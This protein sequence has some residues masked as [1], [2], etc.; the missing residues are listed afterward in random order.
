MP[1][2]SP[3]K[4]LWQKIKSLF[5]KEKEPAPLQ[6]NE[7][8][9]TKT[10]NKKTAKKEQLNQL[11]E[12]LISRQDLITAGK[13]HFLGLDQ[14]KEK[15]GDSW[16]EMEK[17]VYRIVEETIDKHKSA[18]DLF[19]RYK[20]DKYLIIFAHNDVE[21]SKQTIQTIAKEVRD[22]L[23][24][25]EEQGY[26]TGIQVAVTQ[27]E[28]SKL[29]QSPD[30]DDKLEIMFRPEE[31]SPSTIK[32]QEIKAAPAK[33][34]LKTSAPPKSPAPKIS[35]DYLPLW[36]VQKNVL[37]TY[38]FRAKGM[39]KDGEA[40]EGH[41]S[42]FLGMSPT[43]MATSDMNILQTVKAELNKMVKEE[44]QL[45]IACPVHFNTLIQDR[46]L[47]KYLF[48]CQTIPEDQKKYFVLIVDNLP[49]TIYEENIKK[50]TTRL[51]LHCKHMYAQI[52]IAKTDINN[53]KLLSKYGFDGVGTQLKKSRH[54]EKKLIQAMESFEQ[55]VKKSGIPITFALDVYSLSVTTS[56][57]CSG[58]DLLGGTAIHETVETPDQ[59]Y[60]FKH[61]SLFK[62]MINQNE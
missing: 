16:P 10:V 15:F 31:P 47:E 14:I 39:I 40:S 54:G 2:T 4:N 8:T 25:L 12:Q 1:N 21:K 6:K 11:L 30:I 41:D 38:L 61:N 27:I 51:K 62:N 18:K 56:A 35:H 59:I 29:S 13:M 60:H 55:T 3:K 7:P 43:Q 50:F 20:N 28:A 49:D 45:L 58:I 23:L 44:R 26:N 5:S 48:E 53:L 42:Y 33:K 17:L 32:Q 34:P 24:K 9:P 19:I 46:F 52:P 37:S 22:R 36:D 57:V